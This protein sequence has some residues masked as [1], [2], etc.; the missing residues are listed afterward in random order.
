M[1]HISTLSNNVLIDKIKGIIYGNALGDAVGLA[2]EFLT[3]NQAKQLFGKPKVIEFPIPNHK[4]N[5]H[6]RRWKTG[7][8]TDDTDQLLLIMLSMIKRNSLE[9]DEQDFAHYMLDW[10]NRGFSE[11][12]DFGGMG[13]GMTVMR[14][15]FDHD[16]LDDPH[17]AAHKIWTDSGRYLAANGAVMRTAVLGI[18]GFDDIDFVKSNTVKICKTTHADTRCIASCIVITVLIA[19]ILKGKNTDDQELVEEH[20]QE[21]MKHAREY[22]DPEHTEVFEQYC[23]DQ[24]ID[25]MELDDSKSIGYTLKCMAAGIYGLRS[26]K[27]FAETITDIVMAAGDADTNGAV[28]GALAGAKYGYS[29]LPSDWLNQLCFKEW[30][31]HKVD[32]FLALLDIPKNDQV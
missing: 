23:R 14:V 20:I 16:F 5:A 24:T 18:P 10:K 32:A 29:N 1:R 2:T 15:M 8:W 17:N 21:S 12:G 4:K 6:N 22:L 19:L 28:C 11:L 3:Q 25:E 26:Q 30:L 13:I 31:D 7:D 27:P 9:A